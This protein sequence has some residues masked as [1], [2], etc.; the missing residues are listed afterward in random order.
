MRFINKKVKDGT[1]YDDVST[2][3]TSLASKVWIFFVLILFRIFLHFFCI[4]FRLLVSIETLFVSWLQNGK[5]YL[6]IFFFCF[7]L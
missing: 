6:N 2:G 5:I 4:D 3:V 7:E 1:L